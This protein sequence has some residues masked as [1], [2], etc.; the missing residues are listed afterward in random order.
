[1]NLSSFIMVWLADEILILVEFMRVE[2]GIEPVVTI[3][4]EASIGSHEY[5]LISFKLNKS[6]EVES[7]V[8]PT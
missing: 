2:F 8:K 6:V 5:A 3:I 4:V 1:M 7:R